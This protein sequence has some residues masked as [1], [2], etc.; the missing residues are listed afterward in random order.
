[1]PAS[2]PPTP[3][4][5]AAEPRWQLR[6]LG[7]MA[8][9]SPQGQV[10][11]LPSRA[12][13]ALL[14]RVALWPERAHAREELVEI[15]W[16]GV[17]LDVG[18]N[19]LRQTLSSLKSLLE[20]AHARPLQPVLLADRMHLRLVP[21]SLGCD[22]TRF[23]ELVRAG[24]VDAARTLYRGQLLPG[25]YEDWIDEER[26]RLESLHERL[27][28]AGLDNTLVGA[29]AKMP[30]QPAGPP[31]LAA[32]V[33]LPSYLTRM[34]GA[35]DPALQLRSLVLKQRWVTLVGPGG[36]GKTRLAVE[37]A[38]S[39]RDHAAWPVPA[40]P[41]FQAFDVLAFV[42]LLDCTGAAQAL[43]AMTSALHLAPGAEAPALAL[44]AAL[45]GRRALLVL[46]NC[47]QLESGAIAA[48]AAVVSAL[49]MLHCMATSR[50]VLELDG[51]Q[52]FLVAALPLPVVTAGLL[53][54]ADNAAVALF[55][56]RAQSVRADFHLSQRNAQTLAALV[57]ELEG[58]P[59][60]LELA[61]SRVR[62]IAPREMLARLQGGGT[63]RLDLL[64]RHGQ[65]HS[66]DARHA[67][68]Q[69]VIAWSWERL[70]AQQQQLLVALTVFVTG[71]SAASAA[72]LAGPDI[73]D[74]ALLLDE[75]VA[76]SMVRA[77]LGGD[78]E[79]RFSVY[80]PIR[81]F[82]ALQQDPPR[83]R[84]LRHRLR[85]WA[86]AWA[87]GLPETPSL[88]ALRLEM[89]NLSQALASAV[90][91]GAPMDAIEL[92]ETLRRSLEDV[93]LPAAALAHAQAA[94]ALCED[95]VQRARG[96][97]LIG[98]LLFAA[99]QGDAAEHHLARV[100]DCR[101]L[102]ALQR[103][104]ALQSCARVRWRRRRQAGEVLPLL[105]EAQVLLD[106]LPVAPEHTAVQGSLFALRAFVTNVHVR[107]LAEG[108]RLHGLA[109]AC[110]QPL[111]NQ[112]AINSGHYNLAVC[113]QNAGR[114][115]EALSRLQHI[116]DSA[117]TL[118]DWRRLSQCLNVQG[119]AHAGLRQ[120]PEAVL[121]YQECIRAAWRS[122]APY[123]LAF[124]FWNLPRAWAHLRE[125]E[126]AVSLMA[127]AVVFWESRFAALSEADQRDVRRVRRLAA[128]Q[129]PAARFDESWRKGEQM[130]LEQ[131][132]AFALQPGR[133]GA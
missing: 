93:E 4:A 127:C 14:A 130:T 89:G 25:F 31:A 24:Q 12:A 61:A 96:Q 29:A 104:R 34:F 121:S 60:A 11:H 67:S 56:A 95:A 66:L 126:A 19:R 70:E 123:D 106:A 115:G 33:T 86:L 37:T 42:S 131:A 80:Q 1:M 72:A 17:A 118:H 10:A 90:A 52:E 59:L 23:Q 38:H 30:E 63:P 40:S 26:M 65:R 44:V 97:T 119:N 7:E 98:P 107:D 133:P 82:A 73:A 77:Q 103:A 69:R 74:V 35:D 116:I 62:S 6:V 129:L 125:P 21:G 22:A 83:A 46:D 87:R 45:A 64:S 58:M 68:M 78:D 114:N 54:I 39:L 16:P 124:G 88:D 84:H 9:H 81:E 85:A 117:R 108:E 112:H 47:E 122:M 113:A 91:D 94:V 101:E 43:D 36:S 99:G 76:H 102:S 2:S 32:R 48:I 132:I 92:L 57:R 28:P 75:L 105:D 50:R 110:W 53:E 15:L 79:L 27:A 3:G 109:L 8:L 49:P 20:P 18:R 128:C 51:E 111:G 41:A 100:L 71:F 13:S 55:V 5:P 120:W